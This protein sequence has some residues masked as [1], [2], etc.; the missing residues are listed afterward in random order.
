MKEKTESETTALVLLQ[1]I[2]KDQRTQVLKERFEAVQEATP[3][4]LDYLEKLD[5][6]HDAGISK[7][8]ASEIIAEAL[9]KD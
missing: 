4:Q 7:R 9:K 3:K 5:V 6:K 1:E 2:A 8:E